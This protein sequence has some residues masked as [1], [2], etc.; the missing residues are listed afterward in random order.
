MDSKHYKAIDRY[1]T[2]AKYY[3]GINFGCEYT[4]VSLFP[5]KNGELISHMFRIPTG[6]YCNGDDY[7]LANSDCVIGEFQMC[8]YHTGLPS[9][10][11]PENKKALKIFFSL[12]LNKIFAQ[13]TTLKFNHTTGQANFKICVTYPSDW[14]RMF[15]YFSDQYRQF[16][17]E[18]VGLFPF[19]CVPEASAINSSL[20]D[21]YSIFDSK[22]QPHLI[23]DINSYTVDFS[24]FRNTSIIHEGCMGYNVAFDEIIDKIWQY[25]YTESDN[26][27]ENIANMA[28][29]ENQ[30]EIL[31]LGCAQSKIYQ[32]IYSELDGYLTK[33]GLGNCCPFIV[34]VRFRELIPN[35]ESKTKIAFSIYIEYSEIIKIISDYIERL[36]KALMNGMRQLQSYGISPKQIFLVGDAIKYKIISNMIKDEFPE[37]IVYIP[38]CLDYVISDGAA[39]FLHRLDNKIETKG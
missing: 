13:C 22:S 9:K 4:S 7:T 8:R 28:Y 27:E 19:A 6:F 16:L 1:Y 18:T 12:I 36:R 11:T 26:S 3:I 33:L 23:L 38:N 21:T 37:Q 15:F 34:D 24:V 25:G 32:A 2:T 5:G 39:L 10:L 31:H 17:Q 30:R 29:V 20:I 35:T 14:E